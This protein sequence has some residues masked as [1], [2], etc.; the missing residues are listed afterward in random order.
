MEKITLTIKEPLS[1]RDFVKIIDYSETNI[2][3]DATDPGEWLDQIIPSIYFRQN[4]FFR[5]DFNSANQ[6]MLLN[7]ISTEKNISINLEFHETPFIRYYD[8]TD[9]KFSPLLIIKRDQLLKYEKRET[10]QFMGVKPK[11]SLKM[12]ANMRGAPVGGLIP[13]LIFRGAFKLAARAEDDLVEKEG[14]LFSI[15]FLDKNIEKK[16]DIIVDSFYVKKFEEF[17]KL[18]WSTSAPPVPIE[19][20]KEG[21]FIATACYEDYNHPIVFQLRYFRDSFL[22]KRNWGIKFITIYYKHSPS[23]AKLIESSRVLKFCSKI[24]LVKPIYYISKLIT[25]KK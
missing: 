15:Y 19:E 16:M 14:T 8:S 12:M 5:V 22:Q 17:L 2:I 23:F 6:G 9:N 20:K 11:K 10:V 1:L 18:H 3:L 4:E 25:L 13:S 24:F 7:I 21:C